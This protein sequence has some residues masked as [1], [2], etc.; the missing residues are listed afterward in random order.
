MDI[1]NMSLDA[2]IEVY[3]DTKINSRH[4]SDEQLGEIVDGIADK[5]GPSFYD[6]SVRVEAEE[7]GRLH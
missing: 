3:N 6:W 7:E 1:K 2:L 4:Y 5:M